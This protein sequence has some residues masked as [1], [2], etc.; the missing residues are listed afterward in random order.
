ME[1][2]MKVQ[3]DGRYTE[4]MPPLSD[5]EFETLKA[6]IAERGVLVPIDVDE[7]GYVING[8]HRL[9]AC[10]ELGIEP[11]IFVRTGLNEIG[12]RALARTINTLGRR[13]SRTQMRDVIAGQLR[14][15]PSWS[16]N[17]IAG[18]LNVS[19]T[20]IRRIRQALE[21]TSQIAKFSTFEGA[22]GK[23]RPAMRSTFVADLAHVSP[24]ELERALLPPEEE[25]AIWEAVGTILK[26]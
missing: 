9:R 26:S 6:D 24:R 10:R 11:P 20:T 3:D 25:N 2:H 23:K 8:R 15:T 13:L 22:D 5:F 21:A 14:D 1:P 4:V 12:K 7:Q 18:Q 17:R 16:D 19:G